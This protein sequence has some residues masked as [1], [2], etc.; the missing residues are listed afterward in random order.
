MRLIFEQFG[1]VITTSK[2]LAKPAMAA[3]ATTLL[4]SVFPG[5]TQAAS[6]H[7]YNLVVF[8]DLTSNSEVEGNTLVGGNL[9]GSSSNYCIKCYSGGG[10]VPFDGVGLKVSGNI[11]GN[12]KNVN[13]GSDLEYGGS[14]NAIVNMNG[15]TSAQNSNLTSEVQEF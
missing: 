2:R 5:R 15:G 1:P 13:N 3:L 14:L 7:N 6:L 10:F 11:E 8:E 4:L 9:L 12:P